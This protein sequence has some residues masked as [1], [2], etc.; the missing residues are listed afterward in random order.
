MTKQNYFESKNEQ[1][2]KRRKRELDKAGVKNSASITYEL[3]MQLFYKNYGKRKSEWSKGQRKLYNDI[4]KGFINSGKSTLGEIKKKHKEA[5]GESNTDYAEMA[6]DIDDLDILTDDVLREELGSETLKETFHDGEIN[7]YSTEEMRNAMSQM[8]FEMN[9]AGV[10]MS[11]FTTSELTNILLDIVEGN[12]G[13][14]T[15]EEWE[16]K[17]GIKNDND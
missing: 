12:R 2:A 6:N 9:K 14:I 1:T 13:N 16:S 3:Q 5:Y 17:R 8:T 11:M 4:Q 7:G 15:L 10:K